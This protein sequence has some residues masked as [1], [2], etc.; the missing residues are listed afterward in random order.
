[1]KRFSLLTLL[2]LITWSASAQKYKN[3]RVR[4]RSKE[5]DIH[6]GVK[7]GVNFANLAGDSQGGS[8]KLGFNTG[9]FALIKLSDN[10]AFM[11]ELVYSVQGAQIN[12]PTAVKIDFN[13]INLPLLANIYASQILFFQLGPQIGWLASA[14]ISDNASNVSIYNTRSPLDLSIALGAGM[15]FE[16]LLFNARYNLGLTSTSTS[17]AGNY[18]NSVFQ[19]SVNVP[20]K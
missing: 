19:A 18:P 3:F 16:K 13:Y 10:F 14:S 6:Y 2:V 17:G 11:Q 8:Y 1:M 9:V 5:I 20:I 4:N 15:D 12:S 7:G